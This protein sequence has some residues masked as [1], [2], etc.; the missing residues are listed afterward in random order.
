MKELSLGLESIPRILFCSGR[1]GKR[2]DQRGARRRITEIG[3]N[4]GGI[5]YLFWGLTS[6]IYW[7]KKKN[8]YPF[9]AIHSTLIFFYYFF[10]LSLAYFLIW[11]FIPLSN[12]IFI[13]MQGY[14]QMM[15]YL[16]HLLHRTFYHVLL[17]DVF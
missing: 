4:P 7:I 2:R 5:L 3:F 13:Y 11:L 9:F 1:E 17:Y 12:S 8:E 16:G 14:L 15:Y 6:G 10:V